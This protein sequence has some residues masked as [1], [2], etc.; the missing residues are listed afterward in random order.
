M[1]I[2]KGDTVKTTS[3]DFDYFI[4]ECEKRVV[5]FGLAGWDIAYTHVDNIDALA[6]CTTRIPQS[7]ATISLSTDWK[8][9]R[10]VTREDL[11]LTANHEMAHLLVARIDS[12]GRSRWCDES[13]IVEANEQVA[14]TLVSFMRKYK[15][16]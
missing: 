9:Y 1:G 14:N 16:I 4:A 15:I 10:R 7:C 13:E 6:Q 3:A 2:F 8:S 12:I 5:D 11:R